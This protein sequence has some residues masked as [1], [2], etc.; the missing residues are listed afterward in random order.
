MRFVRYIL[1]AL[2]ILGL[3]GIVTGMVLTRTSEWYMTG[4]GDLVVLS[5]TYVGY[6]FCNYRKQ[7]PWRWENRPYYWEYESKYNWTDYF[8]L[9]WTEVHAMIPD[10]LQATEYFIPWL[11]ALVIYELPLA[12]LYYL[13]W[14]ADRKYVLRRRRLAQWRASQH[15]FPVEVQQQHRDA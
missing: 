14:R 8:D 5:R 13:A 3:M 10:G 15:G 2:A 1:L 4:R 9:P 7:E 6:A 11:D 12:L